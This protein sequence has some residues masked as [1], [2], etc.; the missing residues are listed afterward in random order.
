MS[1]SSTSD[2]ETSPSPHAKV[3]DGSHESDNWSSD[4]LLAGENIPSCDK[5]PKNSKPKPCAESSGEDT[6]SLRSGRDTQK[7]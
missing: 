1:E 7:S 4:S 5:V 3:D 6:C 2:V